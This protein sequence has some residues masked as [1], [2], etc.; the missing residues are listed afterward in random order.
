MQIGR[1]GHAL[2][3]LN[4]A[5]VATYRH[6]SIARDEL[7]QLVENPTGSVSERAAAIVV[8]R[9]RPIEDLVAR[10]EAT[11]DELVDDVVARTLCIAAGGDDSQLELSSLRKRSALHHCRSP[12]DCV[13]GRCSKGSCDLRA[14]Q[15]TWG[16]RRAGMNIV[17]ATPERGARTEAATM[18]SR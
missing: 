2:R 14:S 12:S 9:V 5:I 3:I 8:L 17:R 16:H 18:R 13:V 10:V 6:V 11:A 7:W 4:A 1:N 15:V